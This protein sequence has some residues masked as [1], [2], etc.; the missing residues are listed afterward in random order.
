MCVRLI[1]NMLRVI[2]IWDWVTGDQRVL[3]GSELYTV[4]DS[5]IMRHSFIQYGTTVLLKNVDKYGIRWVTWHLWGHIFA[6]YASCLD[7]R[8]T[9]FLCK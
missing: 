1:G 4:T 6:R 3:V 7:I 8:T 2:I 9:Y 5:I